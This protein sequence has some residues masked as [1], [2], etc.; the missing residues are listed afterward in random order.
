[1]YLERAPGDVDCEVHL[2]RPDRLMQLLNQ[3]GSASRVGRSFGVYKWAIAGKCFDIHLVESEPDWKLED[4]I[5]N[6]TERRD[7]TCNALLYDPLTDRVM[8]R[9][10]GVDDI[11][12]GRLRIVSSSRFGEDPLRALRGPRFAATLGFV[13]DDEAQHLCHSQVLSDLPGERI[14]GEIHRTLTGPFPGR[15]WDLLVRLGLLQQLFPDC[16]ALCGPEVVARLRWVN[17]TVASMET[18]GSIV[19]QLAL[20]THGASPEQLNQFFER[21]RLDRVDGVSLRRTLGGLR[22]WL[23]WVEAHEMG[24]EAILRLSEFCPV[25]WGLVV[26]SALHSGADLGT[27]MAK[28]ASLGVDRGPLPALLSGRELMHL[29]VPAGPE[30]GRLLAELRSIQLSGEI[31]GRAEALRWLEQ[32]L[33]GD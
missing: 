28:A 22:E 9:V 21:L 24:D 20:V 13:M 31:A 5:E 3:E 12:A 8:D 27:L 14:W 30:I 11:E 1:M 32:E 2:T 16:R 26:F 6:A 18:P 17:E 33:S 15:G 7:F 25:P 10:G 4:S 19:V 29:G 23:H